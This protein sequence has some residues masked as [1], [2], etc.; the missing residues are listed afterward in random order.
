MVFPD[1]ETTVAKEVTP[2]LRVRRSWVQDGI[3]V[4]QTLVPIL[5]DP[6]GWREEFGKP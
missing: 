5:P 1:G 6:L 4:E 2:T 3:W